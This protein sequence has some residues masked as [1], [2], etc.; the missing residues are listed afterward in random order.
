M[1]P[2]VIGC[3]ALVAVTIPGLRARACSPGPRAVWTRALEVGS[4]P[5][6]NIAPIISY[7]AFSG[8]LGPTAR[9]QTLPLVAGVELRQ[10]GAVVPAV[11]EQFGTAVRIRPTAPLVA[12]LTYEVADAWPVPCTKEACTHGS[13]RVFG[14][15]VPGEAMDLT[16][17]SFAGLDV[18]S[19]RPVKAAG[20]ACEPAAGEAVTFWW[21]PA[22]DDRGNEPVRYNLYRR[23]NA[24]LELVAGLLEAREYTGFLA[25]GPAAPGFLT[26]GPYLVRA[27]DLA[28]NED[29]NQRELELVPGPCTPASAAGGDSLRPDAGT[30]SAAAADADGGGCSYGGSSRPRPF[31][32]GLLL[33][34]L[35]GASRWARRLGLG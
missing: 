3:L 7:R 17:P 33:L 23:A 15:F 22:R 9:D 5:A 27:V 21:P 12:G 13:P 30:A 2:Y 19:A 20:G 4:A 26:T 8:M 6:R 11:V 24:G 28:G 1:N 35:A 25:C 32:C 14:A 10:A 34:L 16:A 29:T 31:I 18:I